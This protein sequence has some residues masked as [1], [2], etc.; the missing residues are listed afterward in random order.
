MI[1]TGVSWYVGIPASGKTTL[2]G[3]H[4]ADFVARSGWPCIVVDTEGAAQADIAQRAA[5]LSDVIEL[6]WGERQ[7]CAWQPDDLREVVALAHAAREAGQVALLIDEAACYVT[8]RRG[9]EGPIL[10]LMRAHRH[11]QVRLYLTTQHLSGDVPQEAISC[12]P[13]LFV[14]R[15]EAR[16]VLDRLEADYNLPRDVVSKLPQGAYLHKRLGF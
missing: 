5:S 2:A 3:H 10:R 9:R 7:S 8:S 11:A 6:A 16:V 14:F 15:N 4:A 1:H 13:D 12:A